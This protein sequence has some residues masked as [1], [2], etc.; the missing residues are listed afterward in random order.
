MVT[1]VAIAVTGTFI[2]SVKIW[3]Q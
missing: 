3:I 1:M 2:T